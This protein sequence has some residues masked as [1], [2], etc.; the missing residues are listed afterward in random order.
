MGGFIPGSRGS[1]MLDLVVLAMVAILPVLAFAI[2]AAQKGK[3]EF[4]KKIMVSLAI[5]LL[6][7][8]IAFEVEMRVVG[9]R[10]L[11]KPSPYYDSVVFWALS[12][13]LLFST[14]AA[15]SM[16]VTVWAALRQFPS[17]PIPGRHSVAHRRSG[18]I[19]AVSLAGTA[20]SGWIFYWLAFVAI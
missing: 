16:A 3:Y 5:I 8:V 4:H 1:F 7:A 13:H 6:I 11:A 15:V 12:L 14:T 19:A 10:H 18:K 9:W 2:R 20:V 17:P